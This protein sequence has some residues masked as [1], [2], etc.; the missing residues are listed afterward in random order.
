MA[1]TQS[2][3]SV[4]SDVSRA[5]SPPALAVE[6][7]AK[8]YGEKTAARDVSLQVRT[9]AI[10]GLVGP[11]GSGKT[12][13]LRSVLGLVRPDAGAIRVLGTDRDGAAARA[14]GGLAG[15]IDDPR[16]Y[17][18]LT[19][20]VN[21]RLLARLDGDG[22]RDLDLDALL[23]QAGLEHAARQRVGGFSLGM[24]QRLGLAA[25][26][27]RRPALLL[28]DE[29]ANGLDPVGAD[30]LWRVVRRLAAE[31]TAVLLS[32]HDLPAI[33]DVCDEITVLRQGAVAWS[34]ATA[35][36]RALAPAPEHVLSTDDDVAAFELAGALEIPAQGGE[37]GL[38]VT[39]ASDEL[40]RF[41]IE[42]GQAQI[43][44]HSLTPG[45][46]PLRVLFSRL[47]EL[48][49]DAPE[50][51]APEQPA[52][53]EQ[54]LAGHPASAA[55]APRIHGRRP[56]VGDVRAVCAV[57]ARK[58]AAQIR[59]RVMLAACLVGPWLF[60]LGVKATGSL[61]SDTLFGQ[62]MLQSGAALPLVALEFVGS[63][64][65]ALLAS[66]VAGDTFSSEDRLGTWP[67]LLT[68]SRPQSAIVAGKIVVSVLFTLGFVVVLAASASV[69]GLVLA[70]GAPLPGLSGELLSGGHAFRLVAASWA[71]TLPAALAW[72][73]LALVLSA[74]TRNSVIGIAVPAVIGA[75]LQVVWLI[76]GPPLLR[77]LVP[78]AAL[79]SWH[80]LFQ[81]PQD[82]GPLAVSILVAVGWTLL[83]V[84]TLAIV[85]RR[86]DAVV[87]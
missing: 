84:I 20:R 54:P 58:L 32:S 40:A 56:R 13:I 25:A 45:A 50:S 35:E 7:L 47:T 86:R 29:P 62:W 16:F 34:G 81:T 8:R 49:E 52:V 55:A 76:D 69:A 82:V 77:E 46:S 4:S 36:L 26:L 38:R 41:T 71:A 17:P 78:T 48:P 87:G 43:G 2:L 18:Y 24:R 30:E 74:R 53:G 85:I 79:D 15:L 75:L 39:A 61:P 14:E 22:R 80:G 70:G 10:H 51:T 57:E 64:V 66:L 5:V 72:T 68:R 6:G 19:A 31:G 59:P 21:L 33:D 12:T 9:G 65:F 63:W 60:E 27:M 73:S 3:R 11:N 1:R 37:G 44:I 67:T 42:L 23:S 28:L 83:G